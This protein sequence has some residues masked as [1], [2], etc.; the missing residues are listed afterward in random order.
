MATRD[1]D[2]AQARPPDDGGS[3]GDWDRVGATGARA[4][5]PRGRARAAG[6]SMV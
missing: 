1:A 3:R 2:I 6:R 5:Q 4:R